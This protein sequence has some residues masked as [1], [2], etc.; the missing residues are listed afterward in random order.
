MRLRFPGLLL[1]SALPSAA[2]PGHAARDLVPWTGEPARVAIT[3][4][5]ESRIL[6]A[7]GLPDHPTGA[8]PGPGNPNRIAPQ[9]HEF[10]VPLRP[11]VAAAPTPVGMNLFGVAVNGVV[12]DPAAAEWWNDDRSSGWQYEALGGGPDLGLDQEHAHVQPTGTYHYH[13]LPVTLLARLTE[14]RPRMVLLGWAADG[15]PIYGPWII[16]PRAAPA[17]PPRRAVTSYRRRPGER[18]GGP[19]GPHDGTFTQD[20]VHVPGAGDLDAC[21]GRQG[22]TP[23][24]PEGTYH[25]VITDEFPFVPRC[26]RGEPDPGFLRRG[27]PPGG[28]KAKGP[29]KGPPPGGGPPRGLPP[30]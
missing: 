8:F 9:R 1:V 15:F 20:W 22:P 24:F 27:P 23:E 26:W 7:N 11:R 29:R 18:A 12:F 28:R 21:N 2:H 6:R 14:G 13:G 25:Y 30:P 19:G 10:R 16:D 4:E 17:A 5:G 3:V